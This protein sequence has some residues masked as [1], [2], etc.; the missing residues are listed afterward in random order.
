MPTRLVVQKGGSTIPVILGQT[1]SSRTDHGACDFRQRKMTV[2]GPGQG[3]QK[4]QDFL[5]NMRTDS[6]ND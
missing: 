3:Q 5:E 1:S 4:H 2:D 6:A